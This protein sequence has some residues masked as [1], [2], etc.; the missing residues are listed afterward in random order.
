MTNTSRISLLRWLVILVFCVW[1][2]AGTLIIT[3]LPSWSDRG[4]FGDLFG[5]VNALFSGLAFAGLFYTVY[6]QREELALMREQI[7]G[8]HEF[9]RC[10]RAVDDVQYFTQSLDRAHPAARRHVDE[11]TPDQCALLVSRKPFHVPNQHA[12]LLEFALAGVI[13]EEELKKT[14]DG[15]LLNSHHLAHLLQLIGEHLNRLEVALQGWYAG[16]ADSK[17]IEDQFGYLVSIE[18]GY[19]ILENFRQHELV[20]NSYPAIA[21]FVAR[22][23]KQASDEAPQKRGEVGLTLRSTGP[24]R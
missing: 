6:L 3:V 4:Q 15:I 22:F 8:D 2:L 10:T 24:A 9:A 19:Y 21:A 18:K 11:L 5:A 7:V 12:P 17:I 14:E 1:T 16:I 20:K 13:T 23:R